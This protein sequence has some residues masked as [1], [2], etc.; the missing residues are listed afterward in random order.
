MNEWTP[1]TSDVNRYFRMG[2]DAAISQHNGAFGYIA[3][4]FAH[5]D[6]DGAFSRWISEHDR[7]VA[8]KAY[9]EGYSSGWFRGW[10]DDGDNCCPDNPYRRE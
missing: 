3:E 5:I 9:K 7:Q 2:I 6:L 8:E 1:D 4:A 10:D